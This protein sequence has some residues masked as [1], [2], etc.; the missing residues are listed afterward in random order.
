MKRTGNISNSFKNT[1]PTFS[2]E[3][4]LDWGGVRLSPSRGV[5]ADLR[6]TGDK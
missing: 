5:C 2:V 4:T 1:P 3:L 6:H